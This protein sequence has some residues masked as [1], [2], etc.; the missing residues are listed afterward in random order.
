MEIKARNDDFFKLSEFLTNQRKLL[1][2]TYEILFA[3]L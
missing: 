3:Q 1:K 2:S